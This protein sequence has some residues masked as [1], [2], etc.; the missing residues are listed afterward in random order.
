M[1]QSNVKKEGILQPCYTK[2][3][4]TSYWHYFEKRKNL[5]LLAGD[6]EFVET[7]RTAVSKE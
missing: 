1:E 3:G 4:N 6:Q 7:H 2:G 5:Y